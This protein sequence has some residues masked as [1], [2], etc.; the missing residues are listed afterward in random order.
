VFA[1]TGGV[2]RGGAAAAAAALTIA[3]TALL[4]CTAQARVVHVAGRTYGVMLGPA[5]QAQA[6]QAGAPLSASPFA[7]G[8]AAPLGSGGGPSPVTYRGGPLMLSSTLHL[9]FWGPQGSFPAS[10]TEP[11]VQFAKDLQADDQRTTDDFSVTELYAEEGN[12]KHI[13]GE[14]TLGGEAF[15]TTPYPPPETAGGCQ[16]SDCLTSSQIR[17]EIAGEVEARGWPTDP[18]QAPREQYLLYTPPGVTVCISPGDCTLTLRGLEPRGFCAYHSR[19]YTNSDNVV[20]F[21]VLP[22]VPL[23]S[24]GQPGSGDGIAGTL[25]EEIH[26]MIESATDPNPGSG[27]TDEEGNEVGDKCVYPRTASF[28]ADFSP[29]LGEDFN[30]LI[31]GDRYYLQDIWSNARGCVPRIGPTPSFTAPTSSPPGEAVSFD[32]RGSFDLSGPIATYEWNYGDGSSIETTSGGTG[33]H[34]YLKPGAYQ[35]SLTVS[36]GPGRANASTQTQPIEIVLGPPRATIAS[37]ASGHTYILGRAVATSFSCAEAT[38]G[39]GLASCTDSGGSTSPSAL[40]T[41]TLG[42]HTYTVTALSRDRQSAAATI[43]YTV[44]EPRSRQLEGTPESGSSPESQG[45]G[46]GLTSPPTPDAGRPGTSAPGAKPAALSRS[47]RLARALRACR[48]LEHS[49]R[50]GCIAAARKRFAP[51]HKRHKRLGPTPTAAR[52]SRG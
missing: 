44:V 21:S 20:I 37:P 46:A 4:A 34:V 1:L 10:Y 18:P 5:A 41:A 25:N 49:R 19:L 2:Q 52:R 39:P 3:L 48:K 17:S 40:D 28:P 8:R 35:V 38:G 42:P 43:E 12:G 24:Y 32:A 45:G 36:D 13:S 22:D 11:I 30:Q 33:E 51:P 14:V 9:V 7:S 29:L 6:L 16:V 15:D 47:E 31:N 27:Y 26:E 23:C 50:A